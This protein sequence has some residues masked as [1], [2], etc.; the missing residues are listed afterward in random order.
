MK[1]LYLSFSGRKTTVLVNDWSAPI[2]RGVNPHVILSDSSWFGARDKMNA[3]AKSNGY[4]FDYE[5]GLYKKG[6]L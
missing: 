2:K 6:E 5:L 1:V 3:Y 4:E